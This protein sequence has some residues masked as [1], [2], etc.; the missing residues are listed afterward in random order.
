[1]NQQFFVVFLIG[2]PFSLV[3]GVFIFLLSYREY[4]HHFPDKRK[5]LK[6]SFESA[7]FAI[8]FFIALSIIMGVV[9][10]DMFK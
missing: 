10:S 7:L 9:L 4:S 2:I 3:A 6:M 5:P 1:M 8:L